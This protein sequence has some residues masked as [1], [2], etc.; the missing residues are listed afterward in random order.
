MERAFDAIDPE[1]QVGPVV[2]TV[3]NLEQATDFYVGKLGFQTTSEAGAITRLGAGGVDLLVLVENPAARHVSRT[4][5]L[6]HFAILLPSR[7]DLGRCLLHYLQA[8]GRLQG[9]A[10]HL[11]SEALY[12]SDPE[13]N[14]IEIYRDRPRHEW[15]HDGNEIRMATD[16]LDVEDLLK[17]GSEGAWL[18]MPAGATIGHMHLRVADIPRSEWF[19]HDVLGFDI[20]ARYG[21]SASFLSAGGYHHHIAVNTWGSAGAPPPPSGATGLREF[22][23]RLPNL[24]EIDRVADR[25]LS[26]GIP[27]EDSST[28]ALV[29]DP[30]GNLIRLV[31]SEW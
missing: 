2:L 20:T 14:G 16:P 13:G 9:A 1:T 15:I 26:A 12:L 23:V 10:D 3:S 28:G 29:R 31:S 17:D 5:G 8:G 22:T 21:E 27:L 11:V 24:A 4:T 30:S 7:A 19:Y 25:I 18:G 6:F